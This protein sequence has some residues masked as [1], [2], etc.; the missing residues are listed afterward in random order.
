MIEDMSHNYG[1]CKMCRRP[2]SQVKLSSRG[3]CHA[4]SVGKLIAAAAGSIAAVEMAHEPKASII[5]LQTAFA[6]QERNL[7]D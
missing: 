2:K 4:C 7:A 5:P 1:A 6:S 3:L